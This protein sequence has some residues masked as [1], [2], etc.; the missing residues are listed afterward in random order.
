MGVYTYTATLFPATDRENKN[1]YSF[2][3]SAQL[4]KLFRRLSV[5]TPD[6]DW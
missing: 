5:N 4:V 6:P 1:T 2:F 3:G